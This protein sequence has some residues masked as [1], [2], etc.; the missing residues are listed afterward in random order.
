MPSF[1]TARAGMRLV[2]ITPLA[3]AELARWLKRRPAAEAAWVKAAGFEAEPGSLCLVPGAGGA[4]A[5][6]LAGIDPDDELGSYAGLPGRLPAG[7]PG[8]RYA[9]DGVLDPE[10]ATRAA[11][12]WALG[13]YAFTRYRKSR[14]RFATLAWPK[15]V[16]K[17][18]VQRAM[19]ATYLVS[20]A[21][22]D[23]HPGR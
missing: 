4:L 8:G 17:G 18:A 2:P 9:L 3:K 5:R 1:T 16:D 20:G 10:A 19:E 23:Q 6:V 14:R 11:L 22:P 15:G 13:S 7:A 21:R 12:G